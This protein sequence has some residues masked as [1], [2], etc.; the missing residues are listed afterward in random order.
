MEYL[1]K[2]KAGLKKCPLH[3]FGALYKCVDK[4]VCQ[5]EK[6]KG[7]VVI[8]GEDFD[9]DWIIEIKKKPFFWKFIA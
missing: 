6:C 5:C 1:K 9:N 3:K 8:N 4:D 2:K 7:Y